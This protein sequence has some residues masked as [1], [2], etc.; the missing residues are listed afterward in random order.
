MCCRNGLPFEV[1]SHTKQQ[2]IYT[3]V[4]VFKLGLF[5]ILT[6]RPLGDLNVI[7]KML[8]AI[9]FYWL[10][11]SNLLMIMPPDECDKTLPMISQHWFREWLG[12]VKQQ[13]ITWANV[14]SVT[15]SPMA[16][17]GH[18]ELTNVTSIKSTWSSSGNGF[19]TCV[20]ISQS[21]M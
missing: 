2:I 17:L 6:Y 9:L 18:N 11:S 7:L 13:A 14:E 4:S 16:S 8:L 1:R 10:V 12:A 21:Q 15:Y 5:A 3:R 19:Q 20:M